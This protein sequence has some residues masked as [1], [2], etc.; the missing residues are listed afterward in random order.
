MCVSCL[1]FTGSIQYPPPPHV[2]G[3][4]NSGPVSSEAAY[5]AAYTFFYGGMASLG[6]VRGIALETDI[7]LVLTLVV[8]FGLLEVAMQKLNAWYWHLKMLVQSKS[9]EQDKVFGQLYNAIFFIRVVVILTQFV[10]LW[11]WMRTLDENQI[12]YSSVYTIT[13]ILVFLYWA[14]NALGMLYELALHLRSNPFVQ[15]YTKLADA[16]GVYHHHYY[17]LWADGTY[18]I[19]AGVLFV[20]VVFAMAAHN[21]ARVD[22]KLLRD[23]KLQYASLDHVTVNAQCSTGIQSSKLLNSMNIFSRDTSEML[24]G[25]RWNK[26]AQDKWL[27]SALHM[28]AFD[29]KV[30]YWTRGWRI[31]N[32]PTQPGYSK[33]DA[34]PSVWFCSNGFD[35]GYNACGV[36]NSK[37]IPSKVATAVTS[38]LEYRYTDSGVTKWCQYGAACTTITGRRRVR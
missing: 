17:N 32:V 19:L 22:D 24:P 18:T 9:A 7:Q 21:G 4:K 12:T 16:D 15:K 27:D 20:I 35:L 37:P 33:G 5:I 23:I 8:G 13:T 36:S 26:D 6:T 10:C 34:S 31:M 1:D 2:G 28:D 11:L 30:Y 3:G 29:Y 14:L 38:S 25:H